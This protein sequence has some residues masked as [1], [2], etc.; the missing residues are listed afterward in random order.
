MIL[1]VI[2]DLLA[3]GRQ[4]EELLLDKGIFGLFGEFSIVASENSIRW[5]A[6]SDESEHDRRMITI[7]LLFVRML[8][9]CFKSPQLQVEILVL[10]HQLNILQQRARGRRPHL[11]RL[12]RVLFIWLYRRCPHILNASSGSRP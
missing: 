4:I 6:A 5:L 2:G 7:G 3:D 11:T 10:R 12:D 1:D 8:G 9:D